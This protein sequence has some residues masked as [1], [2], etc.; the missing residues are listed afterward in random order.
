M[1]VYITYSV[2]IVF[3]SFRILEEKSSAV[4]HQLG[5]VHLSVEYCGVLVC[6]L[7]F[8]QSILYFNHTNFSL[9]DEKCGS[10]GSGCSVGRTRL[11]MRATLIQDA[12][13][14]HI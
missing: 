6:Q 10:N 12:C 5:Q 8:S 7:K 3:V 1:P 14:C 11:L 9:C 13:A 4:S 2:L